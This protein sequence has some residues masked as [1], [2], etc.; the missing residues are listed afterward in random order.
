[1]KK[2]G[3]TITYKRPLDNKNYSLLILVFADA[4]RNDDYGQLGYVAGLS[5]GDFKLGSIFHVLSWS[6]HKSKRPVKSI[7][8][9]EILAA[10]EA[11]DEGK[12]LAS[13]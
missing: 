8:A 1:M 7:G 2:L 13:T 5:I 10:G 3:S 6:S 9:S 4:S 11:I 12:L